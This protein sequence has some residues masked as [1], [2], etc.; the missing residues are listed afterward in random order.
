MK[1]YAL[2]L[3][4]AVLPFIS[5]LAQATSKDWY[6]KGVSEKKNAK[7]EDAIAS[8]KK[9]VALEA[10]YADAWHQLGWC[11]NE[12]GLFNEAIDAFKKEAMNGTTD[13]AGNNFEMGYAYKGL[14]NYDDALICFNKAIGFDTNYALAYKERGNTNFKKTEYSLALDDYN[15]YESMSD[16]IPDAVFYYD[17]GWCENELKQYS[18]AVS[19][20]TKCVGLDNKYSNAY[21]EL[22]YAYYELSLDNESINNY[23]IAIALTNEADY[24]PILGMADVYYDNL[25]NYDSAIVYYE[26]GT[27][28]QKKNKTAFY[29]LGWCF[30]DRDR[31][32]DAIE[33]LQAA[34]LLDDEYDNARTE[35]GYAY[36]KLKKYDDALAQFR[37]VMNRNANDELSRYYA[38]LCYYL[39]NNPES[40]KKMIDELKA[41]NTTNSLKYVETLTKYIK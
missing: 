24:L 37:P 30:N 40:L 31:F 33:P 9:A 13:K 20:L 7:Y 22:G 35:L 2:T 29:R 28:I 16:N 32:T 41:I 25:K 12:E 21:S 3:V 36:Y 39:L 18:E 10:S 26:K 38:G 4:I 8:F 23:R 5:G 19:S 34:I 27:Q 17:K 1:K 6:D 15:K 11:Y 14:K